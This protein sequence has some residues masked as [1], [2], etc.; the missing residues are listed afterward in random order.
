MHPCALTAFRPLPAACASVP[1][2]LSLRLAALMREQ[3]PHL[4]QRADRGCTCID[5]STRPVGNRTICLLDP[6]RL[7]CCDT[8]VALVLKLT[9]EGAP[10]DSHVERGVCSA[11]LLAWKQA[12]GASGPSHVAPAGEAHWHC[13]LRARAIETQSYVLAAAQVGC[14]I[15]RM[16]LC[17]TRPRPHPC[18]HGLLEHA[19]CISLS[20]HSHVCDPSAASWPRPDLPPVA[21]A[22]LPRPAPRPPAPTLRQGGEPAGRAGCKRPAARRRSAGTTRDARATGMRWRWTRGAQW[23]A[24]LPSRRRASASCSACTPAPAL[25]R[26]AAVAVHGAAGGWPST[27]ALLVACTA[28]ASAAKGLTCRVALAFNQQ[29]KPGQPA[30]ERGAHSGHGHESACWAP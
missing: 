12:G 15:W 4:P 7:P 8:L 6:S 14:P 9:C 22:A 20:L 19:Q 23:W 17:R 5:L 29:G 3:R 25:A 2:P 21:P 30:G 18:M 27:P 1:P 10:R 16:R 26:A 24:R 11:A 28:A 13:L